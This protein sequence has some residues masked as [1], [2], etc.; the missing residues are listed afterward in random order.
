MAK[1]NKSF[2][3][4][5]EDEDR[6]I[7]ILEKNADEIVNQL[8]ITEESSDKNRV[9]EAE[10]RIKDLREREKYAETELKEVRNSMMRYLLRLMER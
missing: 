4:L 6:L 9:Q 7:T 1:Y 5:I 10:A 2:K 3:D 8:Y